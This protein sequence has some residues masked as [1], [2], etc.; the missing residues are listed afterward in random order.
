MASWNGW[1]FPTEKDR[2][3]FAGY[4]AYI[5]EMMPASVAQELLPHAYQCFMSRL[6]YE[7]EQQAE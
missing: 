3:L 6:R 2:D 4:A 5:R 1:T 7:Q